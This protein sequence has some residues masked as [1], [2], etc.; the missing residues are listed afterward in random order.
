MKRT[1]LRRP[2]LALFEPADIGA[3]RLANRI[4]MAP[5]TRNRAGPGMVPGPLAAEYYAQRASA[6]LII[7]GVGFIVETRR[8]LEGHIP[9]WV[10][11]IEWPLLGFIGFRFWRRLIRD[12]SAPEIT[13]ENESNLMRESW[14]EFSERTRKEQGD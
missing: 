8:A 2:A 10:Y 4:V 5:L 6:G 7:A 14:K 11:V 9:A 3:F 1:Y 12:D 13:P